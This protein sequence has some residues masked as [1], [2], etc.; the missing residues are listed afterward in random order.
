[1]EDNILKRAA[2]ELKEAGCRVFAWQDD[3]YNR[4]WNK[5]DYTMLYYASRIRRISGTCHMGSMAWESG[6][7]G[8][9]CPVR[10]AD[11]G[12]VSRRAGRSIS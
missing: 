5:G 8:R 1:M 12:A 9:T 4:S 11:P 2:A 3:F 6:I 7:A 10:E